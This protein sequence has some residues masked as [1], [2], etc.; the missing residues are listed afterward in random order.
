[1]LGAPPVPNVP[2]L[3]VGAP[4]VGDITT[5]PVF[6]AP[7][8]PK[9]PPV[10]TTTP[11]ALGA[12]PSPAVCEPPLLAPPAPPRPSPPVPPANPVPLP[13]V[14]APPEP[15]E[16]LPPA[17]DGFRPP[18]PTG[19]RA[20]SPPSS[21]SKSPLTVSNFR[22]AQLDVSTIAKKPANR[23]VLSVIMVP[24]PTTYATTARWLRLLAVLREARVH[25]AERVR[26]AVAVHELGV[27]NGARTE[28]RIAEDVRVVLEVRNCRAHE[29]F[30]LRD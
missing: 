2:P 23:R 26:R 6:G 27:G 14:T 5:P 9:V 25:F 29:R 16:P 15:R 7:P 24:L 18:L 8:V 21:A 12:P 30:L 28:P 19:D 1:V 3:L 17:A 11:P 10:P 4:P 20:P 22:P 13:P